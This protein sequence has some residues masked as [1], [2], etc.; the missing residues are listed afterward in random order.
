MSE[1]VR[2]DIRAKISAFMD[3]EVGD[4]EARRTLKEIAADA[5]LKRKW[6]RYHL[7]SSAMRDDLPGKMV[8]LSSRIRS[9]I[10]IEARPRRRLLAGPLGRVAIAASVAMFTVLGVQYAA[11]LVGIDIPGMI[12]GA[13]TSTVQTAATTPNAVNNAAGFDN[14][15]SLFPETPQFQLPRGFDLPQVSARTVSVDSGQ[16]VNPQYATGV[17]ESA[18]EAQIRQFQ[19]RA[20]RA[21]VED[22]MLRHTERISLSNHQGMLPFARIPQSVEQKRSDQDPE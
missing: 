11:P 10:D 12:P 19:E 9:A 8:D 7:A 21:Y 16:N 13:G 5:E 1:D 6:Y 18:T 20:L 2:E 4:F 15:S 22:R 14:A 3:G 17:T